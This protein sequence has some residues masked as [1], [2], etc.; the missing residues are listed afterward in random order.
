[1]TG[2]AFEFN[3]LANRFQ[4]INSF[5]CLKS[6]NLNAKQSAV[7]QWILE[8][9]YCSRLMKLRDLFVK[10]KRDDFK[11]LKAKFQVLRFM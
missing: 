9:N 11:S 1:M 6:K 8:N 7:P 3:T 5:I 4:I 10:S 2:S